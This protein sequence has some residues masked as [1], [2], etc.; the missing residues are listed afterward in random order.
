M[1]LIL[2]R[3]GFDASA[4]GRPSPILPDGRLCPLP[5]PDAH[6][7]I[8]LG[9]I[10]SAGAAPAAIARALTRGRIGARTRIHLDPDLCAESLPR[11]RGWR[12]VFG[13][14]GA[15]QGHL[16][17]CGVGAGDLFLFFG[18]FRRVERA[19]GAWR[20]VRGAPDVHV[21]HG[22][23]QVR[24]ASLVDEALC[25]RAPWLRYHP[26]LNGHR[27]AHNTIYVAA[28]RLSLPGLRAQLP[29]AGRFE[30]FDAA[31]QLTADGCSR[32]VWRL[33]AWFLPGRGGGALSY[34]SD[35]A[36]W[37]R[38]GDGRVLLR[39]AG[40]GQEF[41]LDAGGRK[42]AFAWLRELLSRAGN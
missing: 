17:R 5:I 29:G 36:R 2:S 19:G 10:R 9:E 33:P 6:S 27:G 24:E 3:K 32:R 4:G 8:R 14:S 15:S 26:H 23:L 40:R 30:R 38:D 16:A 7:P 37:S 21:I 22:W 39:T 13:Q 11:E 42:E 25:E 20:Y 35:P 31:L 18:W 41:V 12:P 28:D 34:H 1:K